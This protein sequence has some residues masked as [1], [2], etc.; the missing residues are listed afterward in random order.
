MDPSSK[1]IEESNAHQA[2]SH[3]DKKWAY[4]HKFT[5]NGHWSVLSAV[6]PTPFLHLIWILH[7]V[8]VF[9]YARLRWSD[10]LSMFRF[11]FHRMG[12]RGEIRVQNHGLSVIWS[13]GS[14]AVYHTFLV[15]KYSLASLCFCSSLK[16]EQRGLLSLTHHHNG[17]AVMRHPWSVFTSY[18]VISVVKANTSNYDELKV[19]NFFF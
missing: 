14:Q 13:A 3:I 15:E 18:G 2:L 12:M 10:K 9:H 4:C 5:F 17:F 7:F 8:F 6:F 19:C 11:S 1:F 16:A